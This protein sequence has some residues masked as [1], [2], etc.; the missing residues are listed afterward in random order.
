MG[1]G[2]FRSFPG[3]CSISAKRSGRR[4]GARGE[5]E[6][7]ESRSKRRREDEGEE[8]KEKDGAWEDNIKNARVT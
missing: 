8:E 1:L 6:Q 7:E 3:V 5:Q 4:A 2:A